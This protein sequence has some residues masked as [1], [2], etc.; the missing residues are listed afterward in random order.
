MRILIACIAVLALASC[1]GGRGRVTG[2]VSKACM[3]AGRQSASPS[4]CSCV[5]VAANQT[6][7]GSEQKRAADFFEDPQKAQDTRQSDN[8]A[9]EAFWRRYKN[10]VQTAEAM[11]S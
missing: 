8:S 4:L 10:F 7:S 11:C 5:Q 3:A 6:L 1:G 2:D 9:T